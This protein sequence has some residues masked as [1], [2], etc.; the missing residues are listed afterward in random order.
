[1]R[2][3]GVHVS[4][5]GVIDR[6]GSSNSSRVF[7]RL[8]RAILRC[9]SLLLVPVEP[10]IQ[11]D[12]TAGIRKLGCGRHALRLAVRITNLRGNQKRNGSCC[13]A[14]PHPLL[15]GM[16]KCNNGVANS[17][18]NSVAPYTTVLRGCI[19]TGTRA[20]TF[21]KRQPLSCFTRPAH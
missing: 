8:S 12:F 4:G 5:T 18:L 10:P 1:M 15:I 11:V 16:Q 17:S 14:R 3:G 19:P 20:K 7:E 21:S 6:A 13:P 2:E 9:F